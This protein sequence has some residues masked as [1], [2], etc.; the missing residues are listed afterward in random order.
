MDVAAPGVRILSTCNLNNSPYMRASGTSMA[1]PFVSGLATLVASVNSSYN[2]LNLKNIILNTVDHIP[3]LSG[4]VLTGGRINA[5]KAV[6]FTPNGTYLLVHSPTNGD[7]ILK[8]SSVDVVISLS[9]GIDPILGADMNVKTSSGE[10]IKLHGDGIAPDQVAGDGYYSG[11]WRPDKAGNITMKITAQTEKEKVEK[12]IRL[13][14]IGPTTIQKNKLR[15][16]NM[17][18]KSDVTDGLIIEDN[19]IEYSENG[20][21]MDTPRNSE[22]VNNTV[23]NTDTGIYIHE[24]ISYNNT[25]E[26]NICNHNTDGISIEWTIDHDYVPFG[27]IVSRNN[28]TNNTNS[29]ID[30]NVGQ[31]EI[32]ANNISFNRYGILARW[33]SAVISNNSISHNEEGIHITD[34]NVD[35]RNNNIS[36]SDKGIYAE[37]STGSIGYRSDAKKQVFLWPDAYI[38]VPVN[39][40]NITNCRY[41]IYLKNS[42]TSVINNVITGP[43]ENM[44]SVEGELNPSSIVLDSCNFNDYVHIEGNVGD[45]LC[46]HML[47]TARQS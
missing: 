5:S 22:I 8:G 46:S 28:C 19:T 41:G 27:T 10:S 29:G 1:T 2:Y 39:A 9:D 6:S 25:I 42:N 13:M 32:Y 21:Y 34:S 47:R 7:R 35:I 44:F 11:V 18:I 4:K 14:V 30:L 43:E 15:Y 26:K 16:G 33:G 12:S 31:I 23:T 17:G 40:N 38:E 45:N 37:G 36:Y 20:I 3:S 24:G